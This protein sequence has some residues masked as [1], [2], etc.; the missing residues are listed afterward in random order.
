M[1]DT[2]PNQREASRANSQKFTGPRRPP[3]A[4][5]HGLRRPQPEQSKPTSTSSASFRH[6]S[7][8]SASTTPARTPR[9]ILS[10]RPLRLRVSASKTTPRHRKPPPHRFSA[11][12]SPTMRISTYG[13]GY[14]FPPPWYRCAA[15]GRERFRA[16]RRWSPGADASARRTY[17][18]WARSPINDE[19]RPLSR[20]GW[21]RP[22][23]TR[24]CRS[25]TQVG[26]ALRRYRRIRVKLTAS[27]SAW[28]DRPATVWASEAALAV[29]S[30][31]ARC[32]WFSR[33]R[34]P[35]EP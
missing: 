15:C 14:W 3:V 30:S 12:Y 7:E 5:A 35:P 29:I 19:L 25:N 8:T 4:R 28:P 9:K 27:S 34:R 26:L 1:A 23:V 20:C 22:G 11:L 6:N 24:H 2:T 10:A 16:R 33:R 18:M 13:N 17:Q 31:T 32:A 21:D